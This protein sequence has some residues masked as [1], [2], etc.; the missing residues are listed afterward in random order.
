MTRS[1]TSLP[2]RPRSIAPPLSLAGLFVFPL[3][4]PYIFPSLSL[5]PFFNPLSVSLLAQELVSFQGALSNRARSRVH[6]D[7]I[8]VHAKRRKTIAENVVKRWNIRGRNA[9]GPRVVNKKRRAMT[10]IFPQP[11]LLANQPL[12]N[13]T[14]HDLLCHF[15]FSIFH[16]RS[17]RG[18][19][20]SINQQRDLKS[21][22]SRTGDQSRRSLVKYHG[23][24]WWTWNMKPS[25]Q[26]MI[27]ENTDLYI[28]HEA[29]NIVVLIYIIISN[30]KCC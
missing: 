6:R 2:P 25:R 14:L 23:V 1:G 21:V 8:I 27:S 30:E 4:S 10:Q 15:Y 22:L 28:Q 7:A 20:K 9:T 18:R 17:D 3:L 19:E 12:P 24:R 16:I 26:F 11:L 29:L 13:Q 5:S